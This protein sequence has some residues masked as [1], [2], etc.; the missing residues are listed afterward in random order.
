MKQPLDTGERLEVR[1]ALAVIADHITTDAE[2]GYYDAIAYDLLG[3]L[4]PECDGCGCE[5]CAYCG[6]V[7]AEKV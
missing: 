6:H 4:C 5:A 7:I 1:D 3:P 2:W